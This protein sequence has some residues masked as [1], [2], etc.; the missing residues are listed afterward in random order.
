VAGLEKIDRE[1]EDVYAAAG[2]ADNWKLL[3]YDVAHQ[4][5]PEMRAAI[6]AWLVSRL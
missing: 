6:R 2:H 3:R 5:T 4:E 1:L